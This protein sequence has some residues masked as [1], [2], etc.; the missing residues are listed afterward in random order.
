M[1]QRENLTEHLLIE[2]HHSSLFL[3][4]GIECVTIVPSLPCFTLCK[5]VQIKSI[6]FKLVNDIKKMIF[7]MNISIYNKCPNVFDWVTLFPSK[8]FR[9][10]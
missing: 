8:T 3:I 10:C 5:N 7:T 1:A 2:R 6:Y 9:K 4:G